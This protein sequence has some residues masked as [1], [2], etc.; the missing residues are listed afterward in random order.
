M[1]IDRFLVCVLLVCIA[2]FAAADG[3][4]DAHRNAVNSANSALTS[5]K[6]RYD[7]AFNHLQKMIGDVKSKVS[8]LEGIEN[9]MENPGGDLWKTVRKFF[10]GKSMG[11]ELETA[12]QNVETQRETAEG[13]WQDVLDAQIAYE[14]AIGGLNHHYSPEE[15]RTTED[16]E[17]PHVK[18]LYPCQGPCS[19]PFETEALSKYSHEVY[20][21]KEPHKGSGYK[22]YSCP[23]DYEG[24]PLASQHTENLDML[25]CRGPCGKPVPNLYGIPDDVS[26]TTTCPEKSWHSEPVRIKGEDLTKKVVKSCPQ[27]EYYHCNI[28]LSCPNAAN[29]VGS[30]ETVTEKYI[31]S[32]GNEVPNPATPLACGHAVGSKGIHLRVSCEF[33]SEQFYF[34]AEGS[35]HGLARCPRNE[36]GETC[37]VSGG[38]MIL[39]ADPPHVHQYPSDPKQTQADTSPTS[40]SHTFA[41]SPHRCIQR[42][43]SP[44]PRG[45][46][47]PRRMNTE[48]CFS[49]ILSTG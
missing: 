11:S 4:V 30:D 7:G 41:S 3:T 32:N 43:L 38:R 23:P 2:R 40:E 48:R 19:T 34:C 28:D 6:E 15:Q 22:Y 49:V 17:K 21:D 5:A 33:C 14:N 44:Q 12:L 37:T 42:N 29:H 25:A 47:T 36:S 27:G 26:H 13:L 20:C 16:P 31:D 8:S 35:E 39:C 46:R 24:C 18:S 9:H 1:K 45:Y 10:E